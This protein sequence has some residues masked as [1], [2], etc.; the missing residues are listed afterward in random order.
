[1][2]RDDNHPWLNSKPPKSAGDIRAILKSIHN[3]NDP[4]PVGPYAKGLPK[5]ELLALR[6]SLQQVQPIRHVQENEIRDSNYYRRLLLDKSAVAGG[7]TGGL[8][9]VNLG[10]AIPII[11]GW[12]AL[13]PLSI[14]IGLIVGCL[15][16]IVTA[17]LRVIRRRVDLFGYVAHRFWILD[18]G[19]L[20]RQ[21]TSVR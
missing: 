12:I 18:I 21:P 4:K 15:S 19:T 10:I 1:M 17:Q 9:G 5:D 11:V 3:A 13:L 2:N 16:G 7:F 8:L 6:S 14:T 20:V